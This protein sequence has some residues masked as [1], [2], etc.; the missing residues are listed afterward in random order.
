[1]VDNGPVA[2]FSTN[3]VG[4]VD[5]LLVPPEFFG[6]IISP[7]IVPNIFT[8]PQSHFETFRFV[9]VRFT[10]FPTAVAFPDF[11]IPFPVL[12]DALFPPET[13][14]KLMSFVSFASFP[15]ASFTVK[16]LDASARLVDPGPVVTFLETVGETL[17]N[18]PF[19]LPSDI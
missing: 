2:L 12:K 10:T 3:V 6:K 16:L 4:L 7:T 9:F 11:M 18:E 13:A 5:V 15:L 8:T 14:C 17:L 19:E 1:M